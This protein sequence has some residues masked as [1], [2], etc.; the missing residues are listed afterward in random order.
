MFS[1]A[2]VRLDIMTHIMNLTTL[3]VSILIP[4]TLIP[5]MQ[6]IIRVATAFTILCAASGCAPGITTTGS[7][8][9]NAIASGIDQLIGDPGQS[10][11]VFAFAQN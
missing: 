3:Q 4:T 2:L 1:L 9:R 7:P 8:T 5:I 6:D 11:V 10:G